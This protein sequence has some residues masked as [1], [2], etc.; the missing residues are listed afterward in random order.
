[1]KIETGR[2]DNVPQGEPKCGHCDELEDEHHVLYDCPAYSEWREVP[3]NQLW[4]SNQSMDLPRWIKE[5][6]ND[7]QADSPSLKQ[8]LTW[9]ANYFGKLL[10]VTKEKAEVRLILY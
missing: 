3:E 4:Q 5:I 1:M 8:K 10:K 9:V 6:L 7:Q 2:M